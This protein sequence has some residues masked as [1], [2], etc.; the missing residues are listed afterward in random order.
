MCTSWC[1]SSCHLQSSPVIS[2]GA[3]YHHCCMTVHSGMSG[4]HWRCCSTPRSGPSLTWCRP[5]YY[6]AAGAHA[7]D[8]QHQSTYPSH[9]CLLL[10]QI[11]FWQFFRLFSFNFHPAQCHS[12][13]TQQS[14][15]MVTWVPRQLKELSQVCNWR[16]LQLNN[17]T[18]CQSN[19]THNVFVLDLL[20]REEIHFGIIVHDHTIVPPSRNNSVALMTMRARHRFETWSRFCFTFSSRFSQFCSRVKLAVSLLIH[21]CQLTFFQLN[22]TSFGNAVQ[23]TIPSTPSQTFWNWFQS[24]AGAAASTLTTSSPAKKANWQSVACLQ[25]LSINRDTIST[26]NSI[27]ILLSYHHYY[28]CWSWSGI[29]CIIYSASF[30]ER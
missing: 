29:E 17:S 22:S 12:A 1:F 26:G 4:V 27:A 15:K 18:C 20:T 7:T 30:L 21:I 3:P 23:S 9:S 13:V 8:Q 25:L 5:G 11:H 10:M 24:D 28:M 6:S 16:N 19:R 2:T 14:L